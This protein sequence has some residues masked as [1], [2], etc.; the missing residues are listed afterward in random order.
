MQRLPPLQPSLE[1]FVM[2]THQ[3]PTAALPRCSDGLLPKFGPQARHMDKACRTPSDTRA[4]VVNGQRR[5]GKKRQSLGQA[6][7][8]RRGNKIEFHRA[9]S[10]SVAASRR[11]RPLCTVLASFDRLANNGGSQEGRG[12]TFQ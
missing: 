10:K 12:N 3:E 4:S 11:R 1:T 9:S 6:R 7:G 2:M 8:R 5:P